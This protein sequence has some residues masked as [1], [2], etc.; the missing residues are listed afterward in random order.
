MYNSKGKYIEGPMGQVHVK[1]LGQGKE[2][3][4]LHQTAWSGVQ[5]ENAMPFLAQ[6]GFKCFAV[7]TPGYG[8]SV[9]PDQPPD[10]EDYA[11]SLAVVI[12]KLNLSKPIILGH[13]TGASIAT[14][15]AT[16][17][18]EMIEHLLL[19]GV[20]IYTE[21]ERSERLKRA[22][23]DQTPIADGSHFIE[24]WRIANGV[25]NDLASKEAIHCSL[26]QFFIAGPKEWYGHNAAFKYNLELDFK[27]LKVPTTVVSNSGDILHKKMDYLRTLRPDFRFGEIENGTFHIIY[28]EPE[29]WAKFVV[30]QLK[31]VV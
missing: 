7:D 22:H 16:L 9:G 4:L 25:V 20:P 29:R 17:F 26:L 6:K 11:R 24:R 8:M 10:I 12:Q 18:P 21:D 1:E 23:F 28:E 5:F 15:F 31:G 2:L 13:H 3:V 14:S 27:S 19:H 30:H